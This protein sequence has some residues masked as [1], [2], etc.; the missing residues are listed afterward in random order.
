MNKSC[1][2]EDFFWKETK[3]T[4][5]LH[6]SKFE[7]LIFNKKKTKYI[8]TL[9]LKKSVLQKVNKYS[10]EAW[11]CIDK[12]FMFLSQEKFPVTV[13]PT[14]QS[15]TACS[16]FVEDKKRIPHKKHSLEFYVKAFSMNSSCQDKNCTT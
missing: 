14:T 7:I 6:I 2:K 5:K 8:F 9:F 3:R 11:Y 12:S 1:S 10:F 13:I 4:S 16:I 15:Q